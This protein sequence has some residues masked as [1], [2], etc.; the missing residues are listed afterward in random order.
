LPAGADRGGTKVWLR[1]RR[2][3]ASSK[4]SGTAGGS[5]VVG[6]R[7][8]LD[9]GS[10][11]IVGVMPRAFDMPGESELWMPLRMPLET[12]SVE[13][14]ARHTYNL[15]A[16]LAPGVTTLQADADL[17]RMARQLEDD[18]PRQ[19]R[20]WTYQLIPLRQQLL[21]DLAGRHRQSSQA[22]WQ[23]ALGLGIGW[24]CARALSA[25]LASILYRVDPADPATFAAMAV[26]LAAA[27]LG[28]CW[29]PA[30]R[31]ARLDPTTALRAD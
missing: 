14:R 25:A 12:L 7:I 26:V 21:G 9:D 31:A 19:Q 10:Y 1:R 18:F 16:R 4:T 6:S 22:V 15:I 24:L 20:G 28:A 8:T 13:E 3:T 11:T 30:R 29:L 5:S 23:L 2:W 17:K 27:A